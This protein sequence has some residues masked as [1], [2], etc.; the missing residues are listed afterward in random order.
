MVS[1]SGMLNLVHP[2]WRKILQDYPVHRLHVDKQV[3]FSKGHACHVDKAYVKNIAK[4]LNSYKIIVVAHMSCNRTKPQDP[5]GLLGDLNFI[6][7][8]CP[9]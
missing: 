4:P 7:K 1:E 3:S 9:L 2:D 8:E 5:D 6:A